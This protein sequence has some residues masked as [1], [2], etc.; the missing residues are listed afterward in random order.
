MKNRI[1][2]T[3]SEKQ[4][5]KNQYNIDENILLYINTLKEYFDNIIL[6]KSHDIS[7]Y[8]IMYYI[9]N[10]IILNKLYKDVKII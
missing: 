4:Q 5:I 9:Y 7:N 1:V 10:K 8:E 3:E 2:I 6:V